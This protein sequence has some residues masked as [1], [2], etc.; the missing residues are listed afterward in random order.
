LQKRKNEQGICSYF[1]VALFGLCFCRNNKMMKKSVLFIFVILFAANIFAQN[2]PK[3]FDFSAYGIKIEPDKRLIVVMAALE[4]AG[5]NTKL[6]EDGKGIGDKF[7]EDL[8]ADLEGLNGETR[9]KLKIFLEQYKRRHPKATSAEIAAPFVSLAYALGP[10]PELSDPYKTDDL[11]GDLL[12]VFDFAPLVREFYRRSNI[13]LKLSRYMQIYNDAG[14]KMRPS[15]RQMTLE[16]LDY[17]HTRPQLSY[18]D[19]TVTSTKIKGKVLSKTEVRERERRFF[20][21]P[22]LL[23]PVGTINFRNVGDDYYVVVPPNTNLLASEARRAYLQFTFDALVLKNSKDITPFRAGIKEL[24][25]Q[26]NAS[27]DIFLAVIRSL[28][29]A[30]DAKQAEYERNLIATYQARQKIEAAKGDDAKKAVFNELEAFKKSQADETALQLSDDYEKGAVLAFYFAEQFKGLEDSGFDIAGSF[31]DML[32]SLDTT[33]E[34]N[35]LAQFSDARKRALQARQLRREKAKAAMQNS[36]VETT[37]E[38]VFIDRM[39]QTESVIKVRN[40]EKA[41]KE[42]AEMMK[43]FPEHQ[44][45]I[46]YAQGRVAS[47]SATEA[48]DETIRNERLE[49]AVAGYRNAILSAGT[50]DDSLRSQAHVALGEILEF[51]EQF[52]AAVAEYDAAIKIGNVQ[53]G[54]FRKASDGK[55]RLTKKPQ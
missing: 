47:L 40:Y 43:E 22:D 20:I 46:F 3:P 44:A 4:A 25:A 18:L 36:Q 24:L 1:P 27:P 23:A 13:E 26:Q 45:R 34:T 15:A 6:S 38:R 8:Q 49:R 48:I 50:K 17:L 54:A 7:R 30:A 9:T 42:L 10:T 21:V 12:E 55:A 14:D 31:R 28:I 16:L 35:R 39:G 2:Q 33:K 52:T 51:N 37:K 11:P 5:L 19:K 41:D 32:L 53:D 29:S